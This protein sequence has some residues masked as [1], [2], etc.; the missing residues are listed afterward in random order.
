VAE[1][2]RRLGVDTRIVT[3][4]HSTRSAP[5]AAATI[6][7]DV[8]QIVKSLVFRDAERDEPVLVLVS[9]ADRVDESR[10]AGVVGRRVERA[11]GSFVRERT[12]FAIG[13][14]PPV[15]H[16]GPVRV[17]M[18]EGLV[19]HDLLW[20]AAGTPHSVFATTPSELQRATEA[21]VVSIAES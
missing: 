12:G 18:D 13:G 4:P 1:D 9:G 8:A 20:A 21:E 6:G 16:S 17:Y 10:L 5:E 14:V 2:L 19:D 11:S 15:G 3:M 7:C